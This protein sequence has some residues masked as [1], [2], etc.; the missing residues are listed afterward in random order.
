MNLKLL[1]LPFVFKCPSKDGFKFIEALTKVKDLD[2]FSLKSIQI[3]LDAHKVYWG[4]INLLAIGLPMGLQLIVFWY[5]S[6]IILP[7]VDRGESHIE[8]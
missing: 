2:T 4:K 6:N 3:I 7:V 8:I 5:W 1:D